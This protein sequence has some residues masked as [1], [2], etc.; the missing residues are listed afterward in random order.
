MTSKLPN[1]KYK[2]EILTKVTLVNFMV[3][4][5]G[6][7]EQ[8]NSV[9]I[10]RMEQNLE[11]NKK[12]QIMKKSENEEALKQLDEDILRI[13]SNTKGSL[14]EDESLIITLQKSKEMEEK[15]KH[16]IEASVTQMKKIVAA[17]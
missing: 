7:E 17:R 3:K 2:A 13:L 1:P 14:I 4:E 5:K 11:N 6:L 16:Q 10:Q 9:V 8:L 15:V 12:E